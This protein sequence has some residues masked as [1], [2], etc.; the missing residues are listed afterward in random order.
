MTGI[1]KKYITLDDNGLAI[2]EGYFTVYNYSCST[3][4]YTGTTDE[5][6]IPGVG[7]SAYSMAVS[8]P[9]IPE[10]HIAIAQ[11]GTWRLVPDYRGQTAYAKDGSGSMTVST[12]G[13]LA[14]GYTLDMPATAFDLWTEDGWVTDSDKISAAQ[15][16]EAESTQ[17]ALLNTATQAIVVWQTKLLRGR[18]LTEAE[19]STL[20]LWLDYID[21]LEAVNTDLAPNISWPQA[22]LN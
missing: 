5:Y 15:I 22:P 1:N 18:Q 13:E 4:E 12:P 14:E 10:K 2:T 6:L 17:S 19:A 21:Q 8:P 16:A 3:N 9:D 7:I 20:D 11:D